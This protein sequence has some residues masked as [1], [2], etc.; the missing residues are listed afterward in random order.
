MKMTKAIIW[1]WNGTLLNDL[2]F[3]ISTIN[4]LL[5]RRELPLL[6][7]NSYKEVFSF[8][9][10]EYY[11]AIGFDFKKED[12][13]IPAKEFIDLYDGG[14]GSCG[15][16]PSAIDVLEY[17]RNQ[18]FRQFVLSAMKQNMLEKTLQQNKIFHFFEGV[19]GLNDHYAVSKIERG[20]ELIQQ[21]QINVESSWIVGDTT[22]DFEVAEQLGIKCILVADGHQ[23][24]QRL[25][26]TNMP[27]MEKL[28]ELKSWQE[29]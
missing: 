24:V 2:D 6:N 4:I 20:K 14:V 15:L 7:R 16:H 21:Y 23:S 8:P 25:K 18:G 3:C 13:S 12:F 10:K 5:K 28:L 22:H 11:K 27:V 29:F 1:D 26:G 19:A 17:F 9:V